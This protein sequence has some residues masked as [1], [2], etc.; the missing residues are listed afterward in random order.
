MGTQ[1]A[2]YWTFHDKPISTFGG[3]LPARGGKEQTWCLS[4]TREGGKLERNETGRRDGQHRP[5][6]AAYKATAWPP[7]VLVMH[8]T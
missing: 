3:L 4:R 5:E 6:P 1:M 2:G 7:V 8:R